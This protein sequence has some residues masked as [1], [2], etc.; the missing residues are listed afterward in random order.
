MHKTVK[1]TFD[2][3]EEITLP[4]V[5][6]PT[7]LPTDTASLVA[8]LHSVVASHRSANEMLN[9]YLNQACERM[10]EAQGQAID[11]QDRMNETQKRMSETE[12]RMAETQARMDRLLEQIVLARRRMFGASSEQSDGQGHLF[13]EAEALALGS[14]EEQDLAVIPEVKDPATPK[15]PAD[16][17]TPRGKRAP[18]PTELERVE[19]LHDVPES[20]RLCPC[21]TPMVVI[22]QDVSEQL[23]IVPMQIRVLRHVRMRY[24]CPD[25]AHPPVTAKL[26]AQPLPKSNASA[27]FLAMMLT[28]KYVDG[29]PLTRFSKVLD[30]H[31]APVPPQT[32]ARWAIGA[33]QLI[34]PLLNLARDALFEGSLLHID[35]TVVQVL[36]E[37]DKAPT[38][39]SYMWVQTGGPPGKPVVI[40][41]YDPSR[42]AEVPVRLLPGYRGYLMADGYKGYNKLAN[43]EGIERMA[44]W[45]HA[46]RRF[47]EASR[48]Q[49]KGKRGLANEAIGLIGV[50]YGIER[51]CKKEK[52]TDQERYLARQERSVPALAAIYAWMQR[53][54]PQVTPKS[55]LGTALSYMRD[56]WSMLVRYPERGDLPIDNNRCENAIRPFVLGRKAWLF[57]DTVAGA[58]ASAVIYSLIETAKANGLEPYH[59][60]RQVLREL[61]AAKTVEAIEALLPWNVK[62]ALSTKPM[63]ETIV[64][65]EAQV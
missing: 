55:A 18:L 7:V 20:E 40:F 56:Q 4:E 24:G 23:D 31:K 33:G 14:T 46:R 3:K 45:A 8:L 54:L 64:E 22:G 1:K 29:L 48:V 51:D 58:K 26:P 65:L 28:V 41:D 27:D 44:C 32:L 15:P 63:T 6:L 25:S 35:E 43:T 47:V 39:T 37:K 12:E 59:W 17:K 2:F 53:T 5:V 42:S 13:N 60:L 52:A 21:G 11:A 49:P 34:L 10:T 50:L 62:A 19:V 38:S 16:R 57:S 9:G 30:R 61:P 36:K